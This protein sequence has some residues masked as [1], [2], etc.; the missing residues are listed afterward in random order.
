[1]PLTISAEPVPIQVDQDGVARIGGTRVTLD[2]VI[3]VFD[4]GATP[5][6]IVQ[7]FPTLCLVDVYAVIAFYLRHREEVKLYLN[8][9]EREA[10]QIRREVQSRFDQ[11]G[12]RERLLARRAEKG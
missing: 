9:R 2:T 7:R 3:Y 4:D 10:E 6:E 11:R 1:M 5:E 12:I 8:D